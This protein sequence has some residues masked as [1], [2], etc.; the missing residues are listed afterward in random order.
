MTKQLATQRMGK[1]TTRRQHSA[2]TKM[3]MT[4]N[5]ISR[6]VM[7]VARWRML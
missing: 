4:P 1:P 2:K 7:R 3:P 6:S 5:T